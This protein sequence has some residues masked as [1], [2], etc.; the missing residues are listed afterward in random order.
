MLS[1]NYKT[2]AIVVFVV[3]LILGM[4]HASNIDVASI[5]GMGGSEESET[6]A[7]NDASAAGSCV[8]TETISEIL[9]QFYEEHQLRGGISIAVSRNERLVFAGSVGYAD[10]NHTV[11]LLPEHRMRIGSL[12]E[13][14]TVIAAM[15]LLEEGKLSLDDLVFER[16]NV[17]DNE[18]NIRIIERK[19]GMTYEEFVRENILKPSGI[20]GMRFCANFSGSDE[21]EY[22][23]SGRAPAGTGVSPG[24]VANPIELLKILVRIDGFSNV[25]DILSR[26]TINIMTNPNAFGWRLAQAG[27][28]WFHTVNLAGTSSVMGRSSNGFNWVI[29]IN[30][31]PRTFARADFNRGM[32]DLFWQIHRAVREWPAGTEL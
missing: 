9:M 11:R 27:S 2:I 24:W 25:K 28:S 20:D 22:I 16:N 15:K 21:A 23:T 32:D 4:I 26:E 19:S 31:S 29:L 8:M 3:S 14:I 18:S 13:T 5:L 10:S 1:Q 17:F 7:G 30:Y 6:D 12:S